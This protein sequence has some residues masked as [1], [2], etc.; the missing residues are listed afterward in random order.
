MPTNRA[1]DNNRFIQEIQLQA[2]NYHEVIEW[3]PYNRLRNIEYLAKGGFSTVYKADGRIIGW[4]S[5]E[6]N[7]K[8]DIRFLY[9]NEN[10][11]N[12][13]RILTSRGPDALACRSAQVNAAD[14]S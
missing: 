12:F 2:K 6:K 4:D 14:Y 9:F 1:S 8:R 10:D 11:S 3:I 13:A 7:W 5:K